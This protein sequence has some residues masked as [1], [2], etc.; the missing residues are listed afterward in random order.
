MVKTRRLASGKKE[1]IFNAFIS[2][3]KLTEIKIGK[4]C[5]FREIIFVKISTRISLFFFR[6]CL[7]GLKGKCCLVYD[8]SSLTTLDVLSMSSC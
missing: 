1:W 8:S 2:L 6:S 7:S 4:L 3:E 5:A